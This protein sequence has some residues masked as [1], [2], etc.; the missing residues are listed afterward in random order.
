MR[1]FPAGSAGG[2]TPI[3]TLTVK[4]LQQHNDYKTCYRPGRFGGEPYDCSSERLN[5][6]LTTSL[7]QSITLDVPIASADEFRIGAT[8]DLIP[9][10]KD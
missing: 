8:F 2:V 7:S 9:R 10:P 5:V 6:T 3:A 1:Y 4:K